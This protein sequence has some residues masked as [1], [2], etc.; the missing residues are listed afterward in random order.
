MLS[1]KGN[2]SMDNPLRQIKR[3]CFSGPF[4]LVVCGVSAFF[5]AL[6][7]WP[8]G[9]ALNSFVLMA[10]VFVM[11]MTIVMPVIIVM[12][13]IM[14]MTTAV[15]AAPVLV[16]R[17]V[18]VVVP[19]VSHKVDRPAAG[20]VPRAMLTP[21]FL[22]P[23]RHVQVDR[24]GGNKLRRPLDHDGL[25]ENQL[26]LR[27]VANIDLPVEAGLADADRHTHIGGKRR[28]HTHAEH[29]RTQDFFHTLILSSPEADRKS[30]AGS[31][32][33]V[34]IHRETHGISTVTVCIA[35]TVI[36]DLTGLKV[37]A[38]SA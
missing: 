14:P 15:I 37:T 25:P 2:P 26:W 7:R 13:P 9:P 3:A 34:Q 19:V 33:G 35:A 24:R 27:D 8:I 11:P 1:P 21:V 28:G 20:V 38:L 16:T 31:T 5:Q 30:S 10:V 18:F 29:S 23:R 6:Q 12:T 32:T 17:H 36:P 22:V 4:Y